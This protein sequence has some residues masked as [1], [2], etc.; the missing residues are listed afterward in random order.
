M[1]PRKGAFE[2]I[3]E[4]LDEALAIARGELKPARLFIPVEPAYSLDRYP[5]SLLDAHANDANILRWRRRR[6]ELS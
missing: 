6:G 3:A 5:V 1:T 4:G 2:K